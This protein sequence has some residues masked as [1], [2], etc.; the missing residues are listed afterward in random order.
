MKLRLILCLIVAPVLLVLALK[1]LSRPSSPEL[2]QKDAQQLSYPRFIPGGPAPEQLPPKPV[3]CD[4][5]HK[6]PFVPADQCRG[7]S[8]CDR[9][10]L[11]TMAGEPNRPVHC[12]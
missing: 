8:S 11:L 2:A 10:S 6:V 7:M 9:L 5:A 3:W 4:E 1:F 12:R